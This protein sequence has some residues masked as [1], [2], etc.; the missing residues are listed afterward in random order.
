MTFIREGSGELK[1]RATKAKPARAG[2]IRA[3]RGSDTHHILRPSVARMRRR[4]AGSRIAI[5]AQ[6][7]KVAG[8]EKKRLS[9]SAD[10]ASGCSWHY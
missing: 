10:G 7:K 1:V 5:N 2:R 6:E 9:V 3:R 8:Y 4:Q